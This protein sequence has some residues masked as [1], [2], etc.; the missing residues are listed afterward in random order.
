MEKAEV[1]NEFLASVS[2][3][4]HVSR[5]SGVTEAAGGDWGSKVPSTLGEEQV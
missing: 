1:L 2:T 5:V 4:S 3:G